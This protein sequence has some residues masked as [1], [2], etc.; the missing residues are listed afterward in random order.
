MSVGVEILLTSLF[1]LC[2]AGAIYEPLR[3][4]KFEF[5]PGKDRSYWEHLLQSHTRTFQIMLIVGVLAGGAILLSLFN[6]GRLEIWQAA[7]LFMYVMLTLENK[8]VG[9]N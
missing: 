5:R 7:S 6:G 8:G 1:L 9:S 3:S 2:G 4:E